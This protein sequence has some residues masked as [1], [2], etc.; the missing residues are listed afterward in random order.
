[1]PDPID[2]GALV[3]DD[4]HIDVWRRCRDVVGL[5]LM[6]QVA[7]IPTSIELRDIVNLACEAV[8]E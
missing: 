6:T 5:P 8:E 4:M 2:R 3:K 1:M 7:R